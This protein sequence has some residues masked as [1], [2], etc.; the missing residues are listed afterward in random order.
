M[1]LYKHKGIQ[2]RVLECLCVC[3]RDY[4]A[5]RPRCRGM[6]LSSAIRN[7]WQINELQVK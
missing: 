2:E 5:G 3:I 6:A 4:L 1:I 7:V